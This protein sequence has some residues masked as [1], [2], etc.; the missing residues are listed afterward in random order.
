[1]GNSPHTASA[2]IHILDNDSLLN[3]FNLYRLFFLGEDPDD[4][5]RLSGGGVRWDLRMF[6]RDGENS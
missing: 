2:S 6:A 1:M 5:A 4:D 3:V